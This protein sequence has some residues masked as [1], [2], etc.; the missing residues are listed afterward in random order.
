MHEKQRMYP[1]LDAFPRRVCNVLD[2]FIMP[3]SF[4][5]AYQIGDVCR[6]VMLEHGFGPFTPVYDNKTHWWYIAHGLDEQRFDELFGRDGHAHRLLAKLHVDVR[7]LS[8]WQYPGTNKFMSPRAVAACM[9]L[10]RNADFEVDQARHEARAPRIAIR[11][12]DVAGVAEKYR[13]TLCPDVYLP[14]CDVRPLLGGADPSLT[15]FS[16]AWPTLCTMYR[17]SLTCQ[18]FNPL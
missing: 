6:H 17:T 13:T 10:A 15:P 16:T 7:G 11:R 9:Q 1:Q 5:T 12:S 3:Y 4:N 8:V 2:T 18:H 14:L